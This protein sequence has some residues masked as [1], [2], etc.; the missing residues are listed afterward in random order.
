MLK[1][2]TLKTLK[3][4]KTNAREFIFTPGKNTPLNGDAYYLISDR[5]YTI[6]DVNSDYVWV[7][8][9]PSNSGD[10]NY[11]VGRRFFKAN[12]TAPT[13]VKK[14][15][16]P[17]AKSLGIFAFANEYE[18]EVRL[19]SSKEAAIAGA[20]KHANDCSCNSLTV[21]GPISE[22]QEILQ[23]PV[24]GKVQNVTK[25]EFVATVPAKKK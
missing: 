4:D 14:A 3:E 17:A 9:Q 19:F 10:M 25:R 21:Y 23:A 5:K 8:K 16:T 18:E 20:L 22:N 24:V 11:R 12:F 2:A 6:V 7:R 1:N 13:A 15:A